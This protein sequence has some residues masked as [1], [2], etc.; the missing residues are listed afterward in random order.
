M[1]VKAG[2]TLRFIFLPMAALCPD[3]PA[4]LMI[5]YI[6]RLPASNG[7]EVKPNLWAGTINSE[8]EGGHE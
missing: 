5:G 7:S 1:R 8:S 3:E 2:A 4:R 6:R